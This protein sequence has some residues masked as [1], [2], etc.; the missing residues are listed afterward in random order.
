MGER[1]KLD[2]MAGT[3]R[4]KAIMSGQPVDQV[5]F[6]PLHMAGFAAK[7]VGYS[8]ASMY[9]DAGKSF[10]AQLWTQEQ[11]GYECI[12]MYNYACY[13]AWEF[14][15]EIKFP[16]SQFDQA[17]SV[18]TCPVESE[19]DIEKLEEY[20]LPDVKTRGSIP[21]NMEFSRLQERHGLPIQFICG[22]PFTRAANICGIERLFRWLIKKP[23]LA[24]R[25][26]RLVTDHLV[27]VAQ[28][29]VDTFG[30]ER[31]IPYSG[32]P[33]ETNQMISPKQFEEFCLP[34]SREL[35]EKILGMGVK[36][37]LF[38]ICG[39][40]E[41]NLPYLTQIPMGEPGIISFGHEID[42]TTAIKVFG[43]TGIIVGNVEPT[44]VQNGTPQQV[45]E[46]SRQCI[47]KGKDAPR[48][49][50]LAT[51]CALP[52]YAPPYNIYVMMK[53]IKDFGCY[54]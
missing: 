15:G 30:A 3:E 38:H 8:L 39:E 24:R 13:G 36:H 17:P 7:N 53:A 12:P 44:I 18:T 9:N 5:P 19:E 35:H 34:Y 11:Y 14:G 43:D 33:T 4:I 52:P 10:W 45:Y 40:Q 47:E 42:L 16:T 54:K 1:L 48:G 32:N 2:R 50:M 29:W 6:F 41:L 37:F 49:F 25:I 26:M 23:A 21:V 31:L 46:L 20:G 28:Y 22:T 27:E 51:G